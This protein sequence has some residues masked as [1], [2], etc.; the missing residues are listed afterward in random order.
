MGPQGLLLDSRGA[1]RIMSSSSTLS[2]L[3]ASCREWAGW[4]E[5]LVGQV[6]RQKTD[7]N[8]KHIEPEALLW[9]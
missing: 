5:E 4:L 7:R 3:T 2:G 6:W 1:R 9:E 8:G